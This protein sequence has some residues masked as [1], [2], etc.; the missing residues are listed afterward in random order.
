MCVCVQMH[1]CTCHMVAFVCVAK[2]IHASTLCEKNRVCVF[3]SICVLMLDFY[4]LL[5]INKVFVMSL[6]NILSLLMF[7]LEVLSK[8]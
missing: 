6:R 5:S 8:I 3:V 1:S 7:S 2:F 4:L